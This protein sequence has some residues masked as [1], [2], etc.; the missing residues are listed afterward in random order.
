MHRIATS[1]PL[2]VL[3]ESTSPSIFSST[4]IH[5]RDTTMSH[6]QNDKLINNSC[7]SC[8]ISIIVI[9]I[10]REQEG[11]LTRERERESIIK[12]EK[13]KKK[14]RRQQQQHGRVYLGRLREQQARDEKKRE[15]AAS[16]D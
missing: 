13:E 2:F 7:F 10:T 11:Q 5:D 12:Q 1:W 15:A 8:I 9:V 4:H 14:Q 3:R 6:N 16:G